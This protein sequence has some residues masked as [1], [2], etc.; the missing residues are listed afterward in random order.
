MTDPL[1]DEES[2]GLRL[3]RKMNEDYERKFGKPDE[4]EYILHTHAPRVHWVKL[5]DAAKC[6]SRYRRGK[7]NQER[8]A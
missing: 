4:E 2:E 8:I 7:R 5:K 1:S 6:R 3:L